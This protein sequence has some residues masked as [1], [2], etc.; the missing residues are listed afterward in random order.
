MRGRPRVMEPRATVCTWLPAAQHDRL[1]RLAKQR[2]ISV[3][4]LLRS[5]VIFSLR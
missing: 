4:A 3:S 2:E 1:I 5:M